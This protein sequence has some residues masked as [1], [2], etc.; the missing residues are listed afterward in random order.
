MLWLFAITWLCY[1]LTKVDTNPEKH[2]KL[3]YLLTIPSQLFHTEPLFPQCDRLKSLFQA[4]SSV[5]NS[6]LLKPLFLWE[7]KSVYLAEF[8]LEP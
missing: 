2:Y 1:S 4:A 8:E 5:Q 3:W 6:H 7:V